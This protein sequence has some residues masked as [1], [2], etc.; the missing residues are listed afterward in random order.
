MS[1]HVVMRSQCLYPYKSVCIIEK[2][3]K[4]IDLSLGQFLKTF[5]NWY[6]QISSGRKN[7]CNKL[8]CAYHS[9]ST[10]NQHFAI[11]V[12]FIHTHTLFFFFGWSILNQM[13]DIMSFIVN[14]L[15]CHSDKGITRNLTIMPLTYRTKL[16]IP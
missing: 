3:Y 14:I 7:I 8:S 15:V 12:S 16:T 9:E 4:I 10:K 5:D 11:F 13:I 6:L 2:C 1:F